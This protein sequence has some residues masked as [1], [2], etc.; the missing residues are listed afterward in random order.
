[1]KELSSTE[2]FNKKDEKIFN[3]CAHLYIQLIEAFGFKAEVK[4][5][6]QDRKTPKIFFVTIDDR[7]NSRFFRSLTLKDFQ[8]KVILLKHVIDESDKKNESIV[9]TLEELSES[10]SVFYAIESDVFALNGLSAL[11]DELAGID[12]N[13]DGMTS[14][15]YLTQN[16][17][18]LH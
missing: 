11:M 12:I 14:Y 16:K 3:D 9:D 2:V 6:M 4:L 18:T 7:Y 8:Q 13:K 10:D 17:K 1:M 5:H 15:S